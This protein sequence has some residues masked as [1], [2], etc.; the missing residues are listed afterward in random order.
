MDTSIRLGRV[1]LSPVG[2]G[3]TPPPHPRINSPLPPPSPHPRI[4]SPFA[5]EGEETPSP[6]GRGRVGSGP[7]FPFGGGIDIS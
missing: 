7:P 6:A 1:L 3:S 5:S 2:V 4:N